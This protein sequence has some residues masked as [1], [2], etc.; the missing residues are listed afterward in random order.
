MLSLA[1]NLQYAR[2]G[3][4]N[5]GIVAYFAAGAYA[6]AIVTQGPPESTDQ[7][8]FGFGAP[9]WVGFLAAGVAPMLFAIL[10]GWPTLR[11]RGEYLALTTF[12]FAEVLGSLL[13]NESRIGNGNLGLSNVRR[14]D[15]S[16]TGL[17][18]T[19]AYALVALLLMLATTFAFRLILVSPYG[20]ALDAI[21]DDEMAAQAIGK[22]I[23]RIRF[24]TFVISAVPVGFAGALYAMITTL[25]AP[26]LYSAEV[27]F[28]VWIALVL[29]GERRIIGAILGTMALIF[30]QESIR[31]Y[32]FESVRAAQIASSAQQVITGGLFIIILRLRPFERFASKG[33]SA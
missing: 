11:L 9:W 3:M 28:T 21:H 20:R 12:A 32:P 1:L 26:A 6:Y 2:G 15:L 31:V 30:I 18:D 10:T 33:R 19:K 25:V 8:L 4:I 5:F 27:T 7:F 29:G 14:P 24:E 22:K 23:S 17:D 16:W 13:L